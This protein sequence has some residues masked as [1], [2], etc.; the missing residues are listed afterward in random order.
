[1]S[2]FSTISYKRNLKAFATWS[3]LQTNVIGSKSSLANAIPNGLVGFS[4]SVRNTP[5]QE[6]PRLKNGPLISLTAKH[7]SKK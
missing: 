1:M 5:E 4:F 7:L 2:M 3:I 6:S